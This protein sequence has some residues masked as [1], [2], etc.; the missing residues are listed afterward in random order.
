MSDGRV[1]KRGKTW[2]VQYSVNGRQ[3]R[4]SAK[5]TRKE[6]AQAFLRDKMQAIWEGRF[7]PDKKRQR[8]L[9]IG[10][11]RDKWLDDKAGKKSI[12]MDKTRLRVIVEHFGE[13]RLLA[14]VTAEDVIEF[15]KGLTANGLSVA[16]VNRHLAVLRSAL[17]YVRTLGYSHRDPMASVTLDDERNQRNRICTLDE[18]ER[19]IDGAETDDLRLMVVIGYWLGMRE[20]EIAN[21]PRAQIRD[22]SLWLSSGETKEADVKSVPL[23]KKALPLIAALPI[24][25]NGRLL[26]YSANTYSRQFSALCKTVGIRDLRF[27]DLRHTAVTNMLEA[28]IDILT[29]QTITGHKTLHM[30]RRYAHITNKRRV[31]AL[32]AVEKMH[33]QAGRKDRS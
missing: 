33:Q 19:L 5:T 4:E 29:I 1:Y 20:A 6:S 8:D 15:R 25:L 21:I 16:T 26:P 12:R 32:D 27:H 18:Y 9:T 28:G 24:R 2:W 10:K 13:H 23:P 22:G 14:T 7:F 11:L 30:T 17:N 3:Y 31:A